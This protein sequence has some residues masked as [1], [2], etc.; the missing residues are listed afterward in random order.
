[1]TGIGHNCT[2][3]KI[4]FG[5]TCKNDMVSRGLD[6]CGHVKMYRKR[7]SVANWNQIKNTAG[8]QVIGIVLT[9]KGRDTQFTSC[10]KGYDKFT[11]RAKEC[12]YV[13]ELLSCTLLHIVLSC[14]CYNE[15]RAVIGRIVHL[16]RRR[17][18]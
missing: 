9:E 15:E 1:M 13:E 5:T 8:V 10:D 11:S 4:Q 2:T 18:A 3:S 12:D 14:S 6:F 16:S 7:K 17:E